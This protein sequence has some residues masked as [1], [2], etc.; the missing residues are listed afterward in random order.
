MIRVFKFS[1]LLWLVL[2]CKTNWNC[3]LGKRNHLSLWNDNDNSEKKIPKV[4]SNLVFI[5]FDA[6]IFQ[7][8]SYKKRSC[9]IW[10]LPKGHIAIAIASSKFVALL[11]K[12]DSIYFGKNSRRSNGLNCL[13]VRPFPKFNW[14]ILTTSDV[15]NLIFLNVWI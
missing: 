14:S 6:K 11:S 5:N 3:L 8:K 7:K 13:H 10:S 2:P 15:W 9:S 12:P 1:G 4:V